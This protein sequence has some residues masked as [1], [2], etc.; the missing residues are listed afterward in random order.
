MNNDIFLKVNAT[1]TGSILYL[2]AATKLKAIS[3]PAIHNFDHAK[4]Q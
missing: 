2:Q 3:F 4:N 1:I